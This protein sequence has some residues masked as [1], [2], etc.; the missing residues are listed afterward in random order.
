MEA[1]GN[2]GGPLSSALPGARAR[3][4]WC[5]FNAEMIELGAV[6]SV[7]EIFGAAC[8]SEA[9]RGFHSQPD[10]TGEIVFL[11]VDRCPLSMIDSGSPQYHSGWV[12]EVADTLLEIQSGIPSTWMTEMPTAVMRDGIVSI[13]GQVDSAGAYKTRTE[14]SW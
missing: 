6:I 12:G 13:K 3:L 9:F 4:A 5:P 7:D 8:P 11:E 10:E 2:C 1:R 14:E